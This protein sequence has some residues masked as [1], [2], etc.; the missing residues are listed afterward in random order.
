MVIMRKADK[1]EAEAE[2]VVDVEVVDGEGE[3]TEKE[4]VRGNK[5]SKTEDNTEAKEAEEDIETIG[6]VIGIDNSMAKE[7][8]IKT[9]RLADFQRI[10]K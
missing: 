8:S 1:E 6:E 2:V 9:R 10:K 3:T 4:E 5:V 7:E